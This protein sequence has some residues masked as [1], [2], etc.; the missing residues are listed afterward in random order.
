MPGSMRGVWSPGS[1]RWLSQVCG[2]GRRTREVHLVKKG[3]A[4]A[5]KTLTLFGTYGKRLGEKWRRRGE[6]IG[7]P[8]KERLPLGLQRAYGGEAEPKAVGMRCQVPCLCDGNMTLPLTPNDHARCFR[9]CAIGKP[10][11]LIPNHPCQHVSLITFG[12]THPSGVKLT[13]VTGSGVWLPKRLSTR[14]TMSIHF[15]IILPSHHQWAPAGKGRQ[16]S[17]Q[18][19]TRYLSTRGLT[20]L[21]VAGYYSGSNQSSLHLFHLQVARLMALIQTRQ[22][23]YEHLSCSIVL[24]IGQL[25]CPLTS[26]IHH[27]PSSSH[28]Y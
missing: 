9:V 12:C 7:N 5:S 20:T 1:S 22:I 16:P 15:V 14:I 18:G 17:V 21:S 19:V 28:F 27:H 3:M 10:L 23:R 6:G 8:G 4:W 25:T 13:A 2:R 26:H 11:G 24:Q